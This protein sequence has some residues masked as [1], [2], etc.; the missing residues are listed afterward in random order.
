MKLQNIT[1]AYRKLYEAF[2]S[3]K[4]EPGQVKFKN[5]QFTDPHIQQVVDLIAKSEGVTPESIVDQVQ[6][7]IEEFKDIAGKA[8]ILYSTIA[9]NIVED[10]VFSR[11]WEAKQEINISTAPKYNTTVFLELIR[12]IKAEHDQFFPLRSFLDPK[13]LYSPRIYEIP[14]SKRPDL[15]KIT[16]A[17]ASP[18][19]EF[20]FNKNFM[21]KLIDFAHIKG[22]K[23][24]GKKYVSN[25][26]PIP[27]EYCYIEFVIMHEF[28]HYT[29]DDFHYQKMLP[30]ANP[31]IINWVGDFRSNY[32]LV[33]SGYEQLPMGLFN[34]NINYDRQRTYKEMYDLVK[35]EFEKLNKDQ[36]KK[37]QEQMDDMS[38]DHEPG[39]D[40]GKDME[41]GKGQPGQPGQPRKGKPGEGEEE[42]EGQPGQP[43][44]GEEGKEGE[45]GKPSGSSED[46]WEQIDKQHKKVEEKM[47]AGR[48]LEGDEADK[49]AK[50]QQKKASEEASKGSQG[51]RGR[52][53]DRDETLD[54]SKIQPKHNWQTLLKMFLFSAKDE[55]EETYQKPSRRSISGLHTARQI[56]AGAVKPGENILDAK[57]IKL[58]CIIDSSGSMGGIIATMYANITNLLKSNAVLASSLF[59]LIKFSDGYEFFKGVFKDNVC[60]TVNN[61]LE[62]P[63]KFDKKMDEVFKQ[64]YGSVTNFT[65]QLTS[66]IEI[67]LKDGYNVVIFSDSD[68][69]NGANADELKRLIGLK[70]KGKVFVMFD[71]RDSYIQ[72]RQYAKLSTPNITYIT[73]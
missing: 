38:D 33:K 42:G 18:K 14:D 66:K 52:G 16:T 70:L 12:Y 7:K 10:N 39:Q 30:N 9:Q 2:E 31:T 4:F 36:Q 32:L 46:P 15:N 54:Y 61:V 28:L 37:V 49:I 51:G 22:V 21:Q 25:G 17:A 73:S 1:P 35:S 45:D 58:A 24:K 5:H 60:T 8:P 57:E 44:E 3:R 55:T 20:Y 65:P 41:E 50:E 19:G 26:G 34:D 53:Q 71:S 13:R 6:K 40:E 56:G 68:L 47:K 23:P 43:G 11:F 62:K 64:H 63:K 67:L 27:D 72:F 48:D 29:Y 59:T 69:A